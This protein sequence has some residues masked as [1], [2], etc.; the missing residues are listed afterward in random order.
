[1]VPRSIAKGSKID[2]LPGL[3]SSKVPLVRHPPGRRGRW[4]TQLEAGKNCLEQTRTTSTWR[5]EEKRKKLTQG[6][7]LPAGVLKMV[8]VYRPSSAACSRATRWRPPRQQGRGVQDRSGRGHAYM[9]DGTPADIV[10]NPLGVPSRMNVGQVLEVH[11]GWAGGIGQR[12]GDMLQARPGLPK[13]ASSGEIYNS[14]G[15]PRK[16][17]AG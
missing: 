1:M 12:I 16:T 14:S 3:R 13:C 4:P 8:K 15:A 5:F 10:L 9:A 17:W 11:L 7:E 6:D 2:R